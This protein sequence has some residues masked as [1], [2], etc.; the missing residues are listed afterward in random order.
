VSS[1]PFPLRDRNLVLISLWVLA[2]VSWLIVIRQ[3]GTRMAMDTGWTMGMR[4][5]LFMAMWTVM[6]VAMMFPTAAPMILTF[7]R[8][9]AGKRQQGQAFV[10]A[11]VFISAYLLVWIFFGVLAYLAAAGVDWLVSQSMWWKDHAVRLG[12][13]AVALAGLYQ[14]SPLKHICL[15][16]CRTPLGFI[17]GFWR[18][19][20]VGAFTMGLRHGGYCLGCCWLLFLM[21]FPL[22][23]MNVIAMV[24][25]TTLIFAEKALPF[26]EHV[27]RI[28]GLTLL[29]YGAFV[30]FFPPSMPMPM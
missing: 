21:L 28:A 6:M 24:L 29:V 9:S 19:G 14:F 3:F 30:F 1:T 7:A 12:G 20:Y 16:K 5:P 11:W 25:V 10:P 27:A 8:I 4:V 18:D 15:S 26:G 23:V 17:L 22:G 13:A 2:G